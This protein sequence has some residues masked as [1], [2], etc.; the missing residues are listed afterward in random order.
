MTP[1]GGAGGGGGG[2][3]CDAGGTAAVTLTVTT[4]VDFSSRL[5]GEHKEKS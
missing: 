2:G 4:G 5:P 3:A 1:A